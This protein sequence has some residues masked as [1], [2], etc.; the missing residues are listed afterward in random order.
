MAEVQQKQ[1]R[2]ML[3]E[4]GFSQEQIKAKI[5]SAVKTFFT[6]ARK[7]GSTMRQMETLDILWTPATL[8]H[9]PRE[10]PME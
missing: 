6:E 2:N 10:C 9:A 7:R 1:Y 5:D 8:M 4:A 3:L